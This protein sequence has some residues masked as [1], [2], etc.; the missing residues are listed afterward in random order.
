MKRLAAL[1]FAI[2]TISVLT[3]ASAMRLT[4]G[5]PS[6]ALDS[7]LTFREHGVRLTVSPLSQTFTRKLTARWGVATNTLGEATSYRVRWQVRASVANETPVQTTE[8]VVTTLSDTLSAAVPVAPD[9]A[10]VRV[11]VWARRRG[12]ESTDSVYATRGFFRADAPPPP[13]GPVT[14]DTVVSLTVYSAPG[15]TLMIGNGTQLCTVYRS[16]G[17]LTGLLMPMP[18]DPSGPFDPAAVVPH[19]ATCKQLV[20]QRQGPLTGTDFF[21]V[22]VIAEPPCVYP[23]GAA[24]PVGCNGRFGAAFRRLPIRHVGV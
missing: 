14:V 21:G 1:L 11:T 7:G 23:R 2:T 22:G 3:A 6:V 5:P 20:E 16:A 15:S 18:T 24:P 17:G 9:S 13:P 19:Y 12:L 4:A 8:R 10:L